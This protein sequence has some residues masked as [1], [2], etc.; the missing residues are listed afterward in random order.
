MNGQLDC[1]MYGGV[2]GNMREQG[3]LARSEGESVPQPGF[4]FVSGTI[5]QR[6][7]QRSQ[8]AA[9]S[10]DAVDKLRSKA[11]IGG[12]ERMRGELA[13]ED[14]RNESVVLATIEEDLQG[15]TTGVV[16]VSVERWQ[17]SLH[18]VS[19]PSQSL[20]RN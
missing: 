19:E 10:Q 15:E 8:R 2:R 6:F 13:I 16:V 1:L 17:R 18:G 14:F 9:P 4:D 7:E 12:G 3:K 5:H 20:S 11:T